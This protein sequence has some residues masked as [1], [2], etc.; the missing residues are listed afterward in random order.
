MQPAAADSSPSPTNAPSGSSPTHA[1]HVEPPIGHTIK[2]T[3][4]SI[5]ISFVLAFVFRGFVIEAYLIPTGSMAPTLLGAHMRFRSPES[6]YSWAVGPW[7]VMGD[8]I[9]P[10]PYQG[11]PPVAVGDSGT[12]SSSNAEPIRVHDPM[13]GQE[14]SGQGIKTRWGD[15][16]FVLKY[17]Y[18]I[19]DPQRFDVVVF[20]NPRDPSVNY[21]KRLIGLPGEMIAIVDGDVF[22]R[23][24]R[25]DD[26]PAAN[27]WGLAGWSICR[28]PGSAQAVMWQQMFS[29]EYTPL[30]ATN[31]QGQRWF[32]S[33]WVGV[34][35]GPEG[36]DWEIEGR[37]TYSYT[38]TGLTRLMWNTRE[39]PITDALAYNESPRRASL[40]YPVS[41]IRVSMG[42]TP[43]TAQQR[44]SAVLEARGHSFKIDVSPTGISMSMGVGAGDEVAF[45]SMPVEVTGTM[46]LTPGKTTQL[47]FW[48][49]D[50]SLSV[51]SGGNRIATA[52]YEW[53]PQERVR[54]ATGASLEDL[55]RGPEY[56][57]YEANYVRPQFFLEF[58]GAAFELAAVSMYRDVHYQADMYQYHS[59]D[60]NSVHSLARQPAL[61]T[62][63]LNTPTLTRDEFF[64][65]G[66]N[67]AQSLD[68]R[69][70]DRPNPWVRKI[71]DRTG[72]V[73]RDLLIGKAFYVYFPAPFNAGRLP[74]PDFG[75]MRLIR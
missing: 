13:T 12:I 52:V 3:V 32:L 5:I 53:T 74:I 63:P 16:I 57:T 70:W 73:H 27:P 66:D 42:I 55:E 38:G 67:S 6:S 9:T 62:H 71:D 28:K 75:R 59:G 31:A 7:D 20:R 47:D 69:L 29:S 64:T 2:E 56:L 48:F 21:I 4:T 50:Q 36:T 68:G 17:L 15:R 24:P 26:D 34:G 30:N 72:V 41:D 35:T 23:K 61:T 25:P 65:C 1:A 51:W 60:D 18:S 33:P 49:V 43:T 19:F 11:G 10:L 40:E 8:G 54:S 39:R 44:V 58:E 45:I 37:R 14:L 22:A 46:E